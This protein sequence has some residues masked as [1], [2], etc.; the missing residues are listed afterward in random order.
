MILRR[1]FWISCCI[2]FFCQT[3]WGARNNVH[4]HTVDNGCLCAELD[5]DGEN[6]YV[7]YL[8][9]DDVEITYWFRKCMANGI[10][11]FYRVGY[12][13]VSNRQ[14]SDTEGIKTGNGITYINATSSDNIGPMAMNNGGWCGA[15]HHYPDENASAHPIYKTAK[16]NSHHCYADGR[17]IPAGKKIRCNHVTVEVENTIFDPEY[18]PANGDSMLSTPLSTETA[19]Y[20]IHKNTIEVSVRQKYSKTTKNSVINYYCLQSMFE[21][22]EFIMTPNGKF[23]DWT[24]EKTATDIFPKKDFPEFNRFI[25]C[26]KTRGTYQGVYLY[27]E[28]LGNHELIQDD[29]WIFN[30]SYGKCYHHIMNNVSNIASK[31]FICNGSYTFFH[32]PL[33]DN[34]NVFVYRGIMNGKDAIFIN[35]KKACELDIPLPKDC[36]RHRMS[37]VEMSR[38][39]TTDNT[40]T[41]AAGI[42]IVAKGSG[43]M[44]FVLK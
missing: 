26:N 13:Y 29:S 7:A 6:F 28:K 3:I 44:I 14:Q 41:N 4:K 36:V 24:D 21:N 38:N 17:K 43:S 11:T 10:Y 33:L 9:R 34:D 40:S 19:F 20:S 37:I 25:E 39:I 42:H 15:N 12:R 32:T 1:L 23:I 35:T 2:A 16:N 30:R 8:D 18:A 27:P 5:A 22:E 31:T